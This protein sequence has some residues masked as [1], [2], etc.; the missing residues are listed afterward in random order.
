MI[1]RVGLILVSAAALVLAACSITPP[2]P[3]SQLPVQ[4]TGVPE[5]SVPEEY[6]HLYQELDKALTSFERNLDQKRGWQQGKTVFAAELAFANG[7]IGEW[8][9]LPQVL[10]GNRI[11]LDRLRELGIGGVAL[12]IHYPLLQPDFPHSAEYLRFY[13]DIASECRKRDMKILVE[14]GAIFS[15]TPYSPVKVDWT[16]YTPE[17]FLK[18]M[19]EQLVLISKEIRPDYLTLTVELTTQE[20]L[21]G[22]KIASSSW[23]EFVNSTLAGIERSSGTRVGAGMGSWESRAYIDA[24]MCMPGIDYVDLHVYPLGKNGVILDRVFDIAQAARKS[25]KAV[26]IGECWLYKAL[27]EE[28]TAGPGIDGKIFNRDPF[29]FWYP[30]D[31]RFTDIVINLADAANMEFVSFFWTRYFFAYLDYSREARSLSVAEMNRRVN[32]VANAN[33]REGSVSPLGLHYKQ[34]LISRTVHD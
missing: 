27:P 3:E 8:L 14:T 2:K 16:K 4:A 34:R 26:T 32:R 17:S 20:A 33:I 23:V 9:L 31:A 5:M 25:G 28:M 11:L 18:G 30:L 22:L 6:S 21:T 12:S 13:K 10:D 7:N 15:G 24:I 29:S 1:S 19:Q